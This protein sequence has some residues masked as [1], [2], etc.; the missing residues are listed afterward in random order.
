MENLI[1]SLG[2]NS[3]AWVVSVVVIYSCFFD[4][5][6]AALLFIYRFFENDSLYDI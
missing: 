5:F 2:V 4:I 3:W 6:G 1:M